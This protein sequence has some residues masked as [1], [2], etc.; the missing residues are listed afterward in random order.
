MFFLYRLIQSPIYCVLVH[1]GVE[2]STKAAREALSSTLN[3]HT[4]IKQS[5]NLAGLINSFHTKDWQQ[6]K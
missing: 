5:A 1:Q 3:L 2:T 6:L 4:H